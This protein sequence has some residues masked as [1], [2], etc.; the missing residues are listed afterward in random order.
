MNIGIPTEIKIQEQRVALIPAACAE[1]QQQGH[2][3]YLQAGAG[4]GCGYSDADYRAVGVQTCPDAESLYAQAQLIIKVKEP[5]PAEWNYLRSDHL[6]FCYLH[7]AAEPELK[8]QLENIGLTAVA[9]ETVVEHGTLPL[10]QPMSIIAGKLAVHAG[11]QLLQH[12]KGVLLGGLAGAER[13]KVVVLGA[14]NAGFAAAKLAAAL[15]AQVSVFDLSAEKM[16]QVRHIGQHVSSFYPYAHSIAEALTEADLV[17]GAVLVPGAKAPQVV[18][19]KMVA[20][21]QPESV[22]VDIAVDQ[23]GCVAT[24]QPTSYDDPSYYHSGVI[25]Y[26]VT[27]MPAAV[28]KTASQALSASVLPYAVRLVRSY[29]REDKPLLEGI[30]IDAGVCTHPAL[31]A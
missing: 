27:N 19:A 21:M 30:N 3:I 24:T 10:L 29:W 8:S 15:G 11:S 4:L 28:A 7:L 13:G 22:I 31:Q 23:G 5:Q 6:L 12:H 26:A 16:T 17:V 1:L 2:Q 14:G 20:A 9:F 18:S 25:H